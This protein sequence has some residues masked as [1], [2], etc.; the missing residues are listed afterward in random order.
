[1][2]HPPKYRSSKKK[3]RKGKKGLGQESNL[4]FVHL[5]PRLQHGTAGSIGMSLDEDTEV[6]API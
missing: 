4:D 5:Q 1:M 2:Q 3:L 6:A